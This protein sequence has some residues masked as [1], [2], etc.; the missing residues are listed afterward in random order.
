MKIFN[1][2]RSNYYKAKKR[3]L[4]RQR[5][6]NRVIEEDA[7]F[8]FHYGMSAY[9]ELFPEI[10]GFGMNW[11]TAILSE[12]KRL[13]KKELGQNL[14]GMSLAYASVKNRKSARLFRRII[15][16]LTK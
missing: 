15:K 13:K 16:D 7:L 12:L 14:A 11:H 4:S 1:E 5:E 8:I 3:E 2:E 9:I 10:K 6:D